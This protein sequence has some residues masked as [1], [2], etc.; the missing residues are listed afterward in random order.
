MNIYFACSITGGRQDESR[1]QAIVSHLLEQGHQIPTAGLAGPDVTAMEGVI[2][3][4]E[5]YERDTRWIRECEVLIAEVST[6]SHGVGYEIGYAL[7]HDKP[8]FCLYLEGTPVSKMITG[9]RDPYLSIFGYVDIE[10]A[11]SFLDA[12]LDQITMV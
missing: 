5:V 9:N 8:V 6:P 11:I 2:Y 10:E 7:Y 4:F 12:Q 1:Y 3:P